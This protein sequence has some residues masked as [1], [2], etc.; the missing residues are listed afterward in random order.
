MC[1]LVSEVLGPGPGELVPVTRHLDGGCYWFF[2]AK[3]AEPPGLTII[4]A[5]RE[6]DGGTG[7]K[8]VEQRD[9]GPDHPAAGLWIRWLIYRG[10]RIYCLRAPHSADLTALQLTL[11]P[12]MSEEVPDDED[13]RSTFP[14]TVGMQTMVFEKTYIF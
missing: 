10:P 3:V 4:H 11:E 1:P 8:E 5:G 9:E 13:M 12:R 2:P 6:D 7:Q 14:E